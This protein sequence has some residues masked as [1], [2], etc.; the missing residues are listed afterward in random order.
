[1]FPSTVRGVAEISAVAARGEIDWVAIAFAVVDLLYSMPSS[2][3]PMQ[4]YTVG[5]ERRSCAS[6]PWFNG[7]LV[8]WASSCDRTAPE[9]CP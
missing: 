2:Q 5:C 6:L 7:D 3:M 4:S 8:G 9:I 1:M